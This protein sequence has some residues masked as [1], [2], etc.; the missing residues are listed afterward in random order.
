MPRKKPAKVVD[1][2]ALDYRYDV[3]RKNIPPAG[4]AAQG[5][6]REAPRLSFAYDPH[7]PS[8]LRFDPTG[9]ADALPELLEVARTRLLIADEVQLLA[10]ALRHREPWLE[11]AGKREKKGFEVDPVALHIHERVSAQAILKVAAR[12]SVQR[13]LFADPQQDYREAVQFYQHD[14]DWTNRMILGDSLQVMASLAHREGLAGKVQ[15]IYVDPP[16]G[17][18]LASNFQPEIGKRDVKDKE[19][20]LTLESEMVKAYRDIWTLGVH[21]YL[22]YIRDRLRLCKD[23]LTDAGSIFVQIGDENLH[24]VR[25]VMDEVFGAENFVS[26]IAFAKT[27]GFSGRVLSSIADYMLWYARDVE[28][29]KY[30]QLFHGKEAGDEGATKYRP[31]RSFQAMGDGYYDAERLATSDQLTSQG[32]S[33][34]AEQDFTFQG[35]RWRPPAGLH[36]KTTVG[37]LRK[38]GESGRIMVEGKS[39]R[40]LRFLDDFPVYPISNLWMDIGGI[41]SRADPKIYV[42]QTATEAIKRCLLMTT[43][44]GDLVLDPTCGSGTTAYVAEQWGRR[45]IT[46][47]TGRV[48]LALAR[49]RLLTA[50]FP[51][52]KVKKV[53]VEAQV[54]PESG[55]PHSAAPTDRSVNPSQGFIYRSVPHITLKSIAQNVALDPIFA[56]H[57]LILDDKLAALNTALKTATADLRQR[58]AAKL[59]EKERHEG[60]KAITDADR[61]RWLLPKEGW[62]EWEV[63][64]DVD[65]DWTPELKTALTAYRAAW[66]AKMDEVNACIAASAEQ[67][68]LVDQPAIDRDVVR[69][70][71]PFTVEA[72][73]PAEESLDGKSPIG[74]TPEELETFDADDSG[75]EPLHGRPAESTNA[76]AYLDKML[77]LL[78]ID[79]VRFP[80]NKV[81]QFARLEPRGG[82]YLH[83]AGEWQTE[84][85]QTHT[86]AV[87]FGPQFGAVTGK[88]VEEC[89]RVA[90]RHGYYDVVFAGFSFDDAA[91]AAIQANEE[92]SY[93]RVRPHM[94]YIRPD[95]NMGE[96]LKET[97]SSQIFTVFGRPRTE[98]RPAGDGLFVIEM[99][100]VDIYN[101]V[102]NTIL[103]TNADK[104][105]A[106]FVDTDYDGRT[107]CIT[108]AF[109]PDKKAWD[110]MARAL[111]GVIDEEQFA[112]LGGTVSL[113]FPVGPHKRA[114]VKVI[115][116]RGNEVTRVHWLPGNGGTAYADA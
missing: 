31:V 105:A 116:P 106:W 80:N 98:L 1:A 100:G 113:P 65:E 56:R 86:V 90:Y 77:R 35:Q 38:L 44:P 73:M 112:A 22:T 32:A 61:R 75:A 88:Q 4:L 79:G 83:A 21:S 114:A 59:R 34:T 53:E 27:T 40:Y 51:F 62:K 82:D 8:I 37:G 84:D 33:M 63:P 18:K 70:S 42:V 47:D 29:V 28:R 81:I 3:K 30:R 52:Y 60:K 46:I 57:Q 24:R 101:P 109:F 89:L 54:R 12:E 45:W 55:Q 14:V 39:L 20:D 107:F 25:C 10:E 87:S 68:E 19:S 115:D 26:C 103:P 72:V 23:L 71:G 94:A 43:E 69:V 67:E 6:V 85:G 97:P 13:A 111:K 58:L 17:I 108:Q 7:L 92:D 50:T 102:D 9:K 99:Q 36:W 41:Q 66:R 15:M 76:E 91:Q 78:R 48:A 104:V 95:V 16:Y 74:G 11:W 110:K 93:A 2:P 96:L 5:P 64:F 49:Q